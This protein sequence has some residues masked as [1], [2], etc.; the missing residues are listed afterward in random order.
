MPFLISPHVEIH[1]SSYVSES[2]IG[3]SKI[4]P[5]IEIKNSLVMDQTSVSKSISHSIA[6]PDGVLKVMN[7]VLVIGG[8]GFIGSHLVKKLIELGKNVTVLDDLSSRNISSYQKKPSL[9]KVLL[10]KKEDIYDVV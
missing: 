5:N 2:V 8:A 6:Y 1:S 7:N 10:L 3:S 9:L 4:G